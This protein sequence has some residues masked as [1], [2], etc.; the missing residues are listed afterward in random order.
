MRITLFAKRDFLLDKQREKAK[1]EAETKQLVTM[2]QLIPAGE[3]KPVAPLGV[4]L[5]QYYLNLVDFCRDFN[6]K[7]VHYEQGVPLPVRVHK[8][9]RAKD[10]KLI[11][12]TPPVSFLISNARDEFNFSFSI[13]N[14]YD[15]VRVMSQ[16]STRPVSRPLAALM[17]ATLRTFHCRR[18]KLVE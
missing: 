5:S 15:V 16:C 1:M 8:G 7:T 3:A 6:L 18:I 17:F 2:R 12:S 4:I 10:Y 13:T 11:I 14:L 9:L